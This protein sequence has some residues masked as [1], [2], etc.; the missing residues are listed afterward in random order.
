MHSKYLKDFLTYMGTIQGKSEET[1]TGYEY[2][3]ALF[4]KYTQL[5]KEKKPFSMIE[6]MNISE[7][8]LENIE[9]VELEDLHDFL[10][11]CQ[12]QRNNSANTRA[13]KVASL[14]AFYRYLSN[15]KRYFETN[16]TLELEGP[17][18]GKRNPVYLD[19]EEVKLLYSGIEGIHYN[20]DVLI[21]TMF[22]NCGLRVSELSSIDIS[23]IK[24]DTLSIIGKGDKERTIYLNEI[25]LRAL[26]N[27]VVSERDNIKNVKD[28]NALFLSQKGNR[29]NRKTIYTVVKKANEKSGLNKKKLSPHKLR[30]TMATLL[31]QNGADLISI[32]ELLGHSNLSTTQIYTHI[33]KSSLRD[34][35]NLSPTNNEDMIR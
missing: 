8:E 24:E 1:I 20:R 30:H 27:Y 23:S 9:N 16:P 22:L 13:R 18:L 17:S 33:D 25:T 12:T 14:K 32:Q 3:I 15:K 11:Y 26:N 35:I 10:Y 6:D 29:L 4:L 31:Y 5:K 19:I 34:V 21:I 2:D 7:V 28:K